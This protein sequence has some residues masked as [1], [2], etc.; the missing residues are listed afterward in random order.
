MISV[1]VPMYNCEN[2]IV[3][4]LDSLLI[5]TYR[6]FEIIL[7]D[8]GST[9]KTLE[10]VNAFQ[11][12][13]KD[14]LKIKLLSIKHKG[15]SAARNKGIEAAE[16]DYIRFLDSD[17]LI[18]ESSMAALLYPMEE[19]QS[20]DLVIGKF[21]PA[22]F[23]KMYCGPCNFS[24]KKEMQDFARDFVN[25]P[26]SFYYGVTWNKLYKKQIIDKNRIRFNED[27][28]WCEDFLFNLEYYHCCQ[29]IWY[30]SDIVS[31]YTLRNDGL[32]K[33]TLSETEKEKRYILDEKRKDKAML[34]VRKLKGNVEVFNRCWEYPTLLSSV[35][36]YVRTNSALGFFARFSLFKSFL[37]QKENKE[38]IINSKKECEDRYLHFLFWGIKCHQYLG[39]FFFLNVKDML[40]RHFPGMK[41]FLLKNIKKRDFF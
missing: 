4:L 6:K 12:S 20:V 25:Y 14:D 37:T 21:R 29:S 10:V 40:F 38:L 23:A 31:I 41:N 18:P 13:H 22:P 19:D 17:D 27:I 9:D 7:I 11:W 39:L 34:L 1:I 8:D 15:V 28:E 5:Q 36:Q 24:G 33:K 26:R 3:N 16:G 35:N 32:T 30:I 2:Y